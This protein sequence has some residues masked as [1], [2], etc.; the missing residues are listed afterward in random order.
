MATFQKRGNSWTVTVRRN[1]VS[2]SKTFRTKTDAS[3]WAAHTEVDI[4]A[5]KDGRIP[6]KTF[7]QLLDHYLAEVTPTKPGK[8][9]EE[10]RIK[11]VQKDAIGQVHL[12]ELDT[13]HFAAWRD[14]RLKTVSAATVLRERNTLSNACKRAVEEWKWL[15]VHP[16]KGV[17][18]PAQ[19]EGRD[20][21]I[22]QAENELMMYQFGDDIDTVIGRVGQAF[23][24][25]IETGMREGEI[26][27]LRKE[28][29]FPDKSYCKVL[30]G[31]TRAAKR[32]VPLTPRALEIIAPFM[33]RENLFDL[34]ESQIVSHFRKAREK[35]S[36]D[37]LHFHDTRH[38]ACTNLAQKLSILDLARMLGI[39]D[40][41]ILQRYYNST[42]QEI[43]KRLL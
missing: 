33:D 41:R 22:S 1:G 19:P 20:R 31:K 3:A 26:A 40:M 37:D 9:E 16:M 14:R 18:W 10:I 6:D 24:Y 29:V 12:R 36:I 7:S 25:A 13:T 32:D 5:G 30:S 11:R 28:N 15:I 43:A 34:K 42:P 21:R 23:L 39:K 8:R 35:A 38:E 2:K 4:I 17:N 27:A